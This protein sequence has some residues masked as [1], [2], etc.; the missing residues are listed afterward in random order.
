MEQTDSNRREWWRQGEG[1]SQ[2]TCMNDSWAQT[3]ERGLT[4]GERDVL[5]G[6]GKREI[7]GATV[8]K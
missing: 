5:G 4:V 3:T 6:G 1:I 7:I 8:I 2:K